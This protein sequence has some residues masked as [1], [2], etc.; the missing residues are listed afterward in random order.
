MS[1][2]WVYLWIKVSLNNEEKIQLCTAFIHLKKRLKEEETWLKMWENK[3]TE[4]S[5]ELTN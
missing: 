3:P 4:C 2:H 5:N 1:A